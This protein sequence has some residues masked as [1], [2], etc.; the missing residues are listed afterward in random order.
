VAKLIE[1][2][3]R[4]G[5]GLYIHSKTMESC[6]RRI[7]DQSAIH[8]E[9]YIFGTLTRYLL[10]LCNW[11]TKKS[12]NHV[13]MEPTRVF[14]KQIYNILKERFQ[15]AL[16]NARHIGNAPGR[17]THVMDCEWI[18]QL[19]QYGLLCILKFEKTIRIPAGIISIAFLATE[20]ASIT[21]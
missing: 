7:D 1:G 10:A 19:L 20:S 17:K 18:A 16:L 12:V 11:L 15:I 21:G 9:M 13:S 4:C 14:W 2:I 5:A 6:L 8:S 3:F